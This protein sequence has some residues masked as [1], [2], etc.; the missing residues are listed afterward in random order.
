L[1]R[2][3]AVL[4]EKQQ[5]PYCSKGINVKNLFEKFIYAT[6][7]WELKKYRTEDEVYQEWVDG[8]RELWRIFYSLFSVT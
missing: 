8:W 5:L 7:I 2:I 6:T 4:V 1:S 3:D